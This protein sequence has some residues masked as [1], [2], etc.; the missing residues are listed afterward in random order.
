MAQFLLA[1]GLITILLFRGGQE[2]VDVLLTEMRHEVL[3]RVNEQLEQH[4]KEPVRLNHL[5]ADAL[6]AQLF[7]LSDPIIRERYFVSHIRAFPDAAMVFIGLPDGS[8]Y[9]ARRKVT[10]E[11]QIV[12]NNKDTGGDSWY[13]ASSYQGEAGE[14]QDV[15]RRFDPRTR[16][17]YK[18]AEYIGGPTFTGVY[19][20]FVFLEP[21]V[22]AAHPVYD[23]QGRLIGV[24]G[25]D[26]LL[27]RLGDMLRGIPVGASGQIFITDADGFLVAATS[28][29]VP[30]EG[31]SGQFAR[32]RAVDSNNPVLKLAAQSLL[33][34]TGDYSRE[35]TLDER[36]YLVDVRDFHQAGIDWRIH[37][38]LARDDFFGG[39]QKAVNRTAM[40]TVIAIIMA[41]WVAVWTSRWITRPIL[42]LNAAASELAEGRLQ[43]V[44][45]T[46]RHDEL[47]QLSRAFN[48]MACQL[49][50]LV[51]SLETRVSERTKALAE[52]TSEEQQIRKMLHSELEKAGREQRAMLSTDIDDS[53]LRLR[54]IYEPCMLVSGDFCGY[55]WMKEEKVLFGYIIDVNGH[56][57]A[58]ALQTAAINVMIQETLQSNF[59]LSERMVEI[60]HRVARY[61][62]DDLLVAACFFELDFAEKELRYVAAGIT[63][64]FADSFSYM[65]RIKT[66]GSFL[67]ISDQTEFEIR[68]M[69]IH[70]GDRFC[71][72]SDGIA[73]QLMEGRELPLRVTF[74]ELA[75]SVHTIAVAGVRRDDITAMCIKIGR[76]S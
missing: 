21:T 29:K 12:R 13:F 66:P 72:Y 52:K 7:D 33:G 67:G 8:F 51:G 19:R 44:P 40:V 16:P 34:N 26:Y 2:A 75:A 46:E 68:S 54:I 37:V 53:R 9:G 61:F 48:K 38:V 42:R 50:D 4:M 17:W 73:D 15:F 10:G 30:F 63:E 35:I 23:T 6:D 5:N 20:H 69:S 49:T 59:S 36:S 22:T 55:R 60:N 47:G 64:F 27:S 76:L 28:L 32:I 14:R 62:K 43:A 11:I 56:G 70:E 58:T 74:D 45:D 18:S 24:F 3:E 71:F 31:Q 25:V 57:V 41:F 39:I 1:A 65:G